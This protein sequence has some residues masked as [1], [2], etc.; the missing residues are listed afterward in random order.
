[1]PKYPKNDN[2]IINNESYFEVKE[3]RGIKVLRIKRTKTFEGLQGQEFD[4]LTEHVWTSSDK[5]FKI[6]H[7]YGS[8]EFWWVIGILNGKPTDAHY[9][10]GD[11]IN[12]PT[13]P[14]QIS[15][16]LR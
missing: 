9:S 16:L 7:K 11:V 1:M 10:I 12:I 15:E 13:K 2:A 6:S 8:T 5:L 4:L 14:N 3:A